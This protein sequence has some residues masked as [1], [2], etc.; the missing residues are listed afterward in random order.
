MALI[1]KPSSNAVSITTTNVAFFKLEFVQTDGVT[2]SLLARTIAFVDQ[3]LEKE[4][5]KALSDSKLQY[6]DDIVF[7][8]DV[9]IEAVKSRTE[10][11]YTGML[12]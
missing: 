7:P 4:L 1:R 3:L 2:W 12:A 9:H 10:G 6:D 8:N 5:S 11:M